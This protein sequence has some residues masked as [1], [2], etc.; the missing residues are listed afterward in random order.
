MVPRIPKVSMDIMGSAQELARRSM[1]EHVKE[2]GWFHWF[3]YWCKLFIENMKCSSDQAAGNEKITD[4][5]YSIHFPTYTHI[6]YCFSASALAEYTPVS[7]FHI[8][9]SDD[10]DIE[11]LPWLHDFWY[12]LIPLFLFT[13]TLPSFVPSSTP[14]VWIDFLFTRSLLDSQ[15]LSIHISINIPSF[16]H[17]Y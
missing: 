6:I 2:N 14:L 9:M 3:F 15:P 17:Y 13:F 10:D 12:M 8:S 16:A 5:I 4:Q 11:I 7:P 1:E